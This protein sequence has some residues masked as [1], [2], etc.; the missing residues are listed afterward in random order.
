MAIG[1]SPNPR[2]GWT[3]S[4]MLPAVS[5]AS[6]ISPAG[7][8]DRSTYSSPGASPHAVVTDSRSEAGSSANHSRYC[9]AGIRTTASDSCWSVSHSGSCPPAAMTAWIS[10]SPSCSSTPGNVG[11]PMS[12]P[13]S[14]MAASSA[15]ALAGVSR[16]TAF[17][18]RACLVG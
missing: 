13:R 11:A 2:G 17:P 6:T 10:A 14:R 8:W 4:T 3:S 7:S 9:A 15:T 1:F 16:P 12:Y 18:I 5:A